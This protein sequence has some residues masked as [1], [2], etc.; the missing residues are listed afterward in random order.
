MNIGHISGGT[1]AGWR[2]VVQ[3]PTPWTCVCQGSR[4]IGTN[5]GYLTKCPCG[6]PRPN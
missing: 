6:N 1:N 2:K 4:V 3:K 5:P